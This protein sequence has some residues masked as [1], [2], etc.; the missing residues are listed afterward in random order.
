MSKEIFIDTKQ[1]DRLTI[2][3]KGFE[4]EVGEATF[5]ALNRTIDHVVTQVGKIVPKSYAIKSSEVK[6]SFKGGIKRPSKNNLEASLTSKGHTLSF[7]HFPYTPK[8]PRRGGRSVFQNAVMVTIKKSKGK[9]LSKKG[10]VASTGAKSVDKTQYNVFMRLGKS[11]LPIAPIRT[12][13]IP[14]MITNEGIGEQIQDIANKKLSERLEHEI[15]FRMT[16]SGKR[17]K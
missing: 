16:S 8:R 5:H 1:I 4:Q 12:L 7:A 14:Q 17:I 2:E 9:I 15:I 3:L 11:R 10:F 13:S 6:E